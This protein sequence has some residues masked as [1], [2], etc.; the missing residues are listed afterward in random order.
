MQLAAGAYF[1]TP[2][3][4]RDAGGIHLSEHAY[5][6]DLIVPRHAHERPYVC[7]VVAGGYDE[8]ARGGSRRCEPAALLLHPSG[9][10]HEERFA[11]SGARIFHVEL[12]PR[13]V[14]SVRAIGVSLDRDLH[15]ADG[16]A[17]ALARRLRGELLAW[18][19]VSP[20]AVEGLALQLLA[21]LGRPPRARSGEPAWL[22]RLLELLRERFRD[23][24][25]LDELAREA[26]VHPAHLARAF[27]E[28][29]RCTIGEHVRSLRVEHACRALATTELSLAAIAADAGFA[30]QAHFARVFR[31]QIGTSPSE[32]RTSASSAFKR[33]RRGTR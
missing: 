31:R 24:L 21:E 2:T 1:G 28:H 4:R 27:R 6:P 23:R 33:G 13:I 20:L 26:G 19:A 18:D 8:R 14:D 11:P 30:D 17:A 12:P 29:R 9:E 7:L 10:E 15:A 22:A 5:A 32:Y 25:A 16:P 3:H